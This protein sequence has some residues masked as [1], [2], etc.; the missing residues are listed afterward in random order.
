MNTDQGYQAMQKNEEKY[1]MVK[2]GKLYPQETIIEKFGRIR[3]QQQSTLLKTRELC[4]GL[5]NVD[6]TVKSQK[7]DTNKNDGEV[8]GQKEN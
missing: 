6:M 7:P 8:K 1:M 5:G 3:R 2:Q 4:Q